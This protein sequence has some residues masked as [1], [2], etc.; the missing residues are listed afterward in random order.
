[1]FILPPKRRAPCASVV[2]RGLAAQIDVA[3]SRRRHLLRPV[4]TGR[5]T[6]EHGWRGQSGPRLGIEQRRNGPRTERPY[7]RGHGRRRHARWKAHLH[8]QLGRPGRPGV[9]RRQRE[10][11][12][13][14]Q[15]GKIGLRRVQPRWKTGSGGGGPGGTRCC[16]MRYPASDCV[17]WPAAMGSFGEPVFF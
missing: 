11:F 17:S 15:T 8:K 6:G 14:D 10:E 3:G 16:G 12:V 9:G 13:R 1:M 7:R 5:P 4:H 2:V